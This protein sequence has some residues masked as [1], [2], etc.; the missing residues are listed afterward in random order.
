MLP[1]G[2]DVDSS[3]SWQKFRA[4][5]QQAFSMESIRDNPLPLRDVLLRVA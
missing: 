2:R 4:E 3:T 5:M 1:G